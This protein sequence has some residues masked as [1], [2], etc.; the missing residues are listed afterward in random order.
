MTIF[1]EN[2]LLPEGWT[3]DVRV[4]LASGRIGKVTRNTKPEGGDTLVPV[5]LPAISNL[6]SHT[7]QRAMAGRSEYQ[8]AHAD[9]F[10]TW[11]TLLYR[12]LNHLTPEHIEA[13]AAQAFVE[14]Q[15]AGTHG[16]VFAK[17]QQAFE[18]HAAQYIN[19]AGSVQ[20]DVT[21]RL[22]ALTK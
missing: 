19:A 6:H 10:W 14:M 13:I 2:A 17:A 7:F 18:K 20:M 5:L 3:S 22:F 4:S 8:F 1:A 16:D 21:Y 9:S 15:K 11:R 12:F